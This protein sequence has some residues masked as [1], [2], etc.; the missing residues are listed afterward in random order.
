MNGYEDYPFVVTKLS[1]D[2]KR[3]YDVQSFPQ[4]L[5]GIQWLV[6]TERD[7]RVDRN[8]LSTLPPIMHPVGNP[9]ADWG[10]GRYVPYRRAGEFQF[11]PTPSFNPGSIEMETT[12][13]NQADKLIGLD[14]G[15]PLSSIQQQYFV[16]KFLTHVRD[17]LRLTYKCYQRFG[18][19]QVFFRVTGVSDPQRFDRGDPNENF[20]IIINYDVMQNDPDNV[21]NHLKQF[22]AMLQLDRNGRIDIDALL[23]FGAASINP[24]LAD[25][26]LRP[27]GVAQEQV[28]KQVTDDLSKIYAGIEVGA[29][30]N[31]AQVALQ[32]VQ[33]Y[34]QQPDVNQR[35]QQDKAFAA[36]LQKYAQQYQFQ[37]Q[38]AQNAQIGRVGTAPAAM[39]ET[40][41]QGMQQQ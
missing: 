30:P 33:Q 39:G 22:T 40:P 13:L 36:R 21:D 11:G 4:M 3:L 37:M 19:D 14:V 28:V 9:P 7:S 32:V 35:L 41:T 5:K 6:K 12:Q 34:A 23:E 10:P 26:I 1:E 31:G 15:N 27:A 8:S 25:T 17:V 16:D 20:D 29:R 18:P 2:N 24:V 38:Q